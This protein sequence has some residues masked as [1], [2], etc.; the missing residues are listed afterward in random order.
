MGQYRP[1]FNI[2]LE[3]DYFSAGKFPGVSLK[4]TP[5]S[6]KLMNNANLVS[7]VRQDGL[8]V[9]YDA[10][11]LDT[12]KVY[13][14]DNDEPLKL[15]FECD[16]ETESFH[17]FT[18]ASSFASNKTLFFDSNN[19]DKS[20]IGKKYLHSNEFVSSDDLAENFNSAAA[21]NEQFN[22]VLHFSPDRAL[23]FT[24]AQ[25][26]KNPTGKTLLAANDVEQ[27]RA[28]AQ[29]MARH[30]TLKSRKQPSVGLI[31]IQ[32]TPGELEQL[33]AAPVTTYNDY[34]IRFQA[35]E[36]HWKYFLVGEANREGAFIKDVRGEIDFDD[37]G[38]E[39]LADGRFAR[40]FLSRQA[41]PL[42][43]RAKPKFQLQIMKNNRPKVLVSRLQVASSKRINRVTVDNQELFV[44]EIYVNF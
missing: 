1:M 11:Y 18:N 41:M 10:D 38:E 16:A 24:A 27:R 15:N 43:D 37:L 3:H 34:Y 8:T 33:T 9:F 13:A 29:A 35:R 26:E 5:E 31:S 22:S 30:S 14:A 19:T 25:T 23:L 12:L 7:R 21:L 2:A 40:V 32:I 42:V 4:P 28:I 36:T 39:Q 20:F 44:S 17:N 6:E